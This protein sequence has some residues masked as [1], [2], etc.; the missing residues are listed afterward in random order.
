MNQ[1]KFRVSVNYEQIVTP[2]K[3]AQAVSQLEELGVEYT[4]ETVRENGHINATPTP[5]KALNGEEIVFTEKSKLRK[6]KG[7]GVR[8]RNRLSESCKEAWQKANAFKAE[9][10]MSRTEATA[11]A[12]LN[13]AAGNKHSRIDWLSAKKIASSFGC[14]NPNDALKM[15]RLE[16]L[17]SR[18]DRGLYRLRNSLPETG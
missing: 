13:E 9:H 5:I 17:L 14:T 11:R 18:E 12:I 4:V 3:L 7:R 15:L 1:P 16:G 10:G 6:G 2:D 8:Y